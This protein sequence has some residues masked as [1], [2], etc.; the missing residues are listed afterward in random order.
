MSDAQ[1]AVEAFN[2]IEALIWFGVAVGLPFVIRPD[3]RRR[4]ISVLAAAFGFVLF[5]ITDLLEAD[6]A[7]AM[8]G[9][10]WILKITCATFL[11]AC[12]FDYIGWKNFR[13]TD[14]WFLFGLFCLAASVAL[15]LLG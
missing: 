1:A 9:W 14:R 4:R 10:L 8:P 12:R 6:T 15:I 13:F 2:R 11:L 3:D 5:G 7:G